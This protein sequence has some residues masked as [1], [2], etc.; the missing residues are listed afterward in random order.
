MSIR[1]SRFVGN[2]LA[3]QFDRDHI[4]ASNVKKAVMS[5][6]PTEEKLVAFYSRHQTA[7]LR[8]ACDAIQETPDTLSDERTMN[9]ADMWAKYFIVISSSVSLVLELLQK[10]DEIE[11]SKLQENYEQFL[12][13]NKLWKLVSC[14]DSGIRRTICELLIQCCYKQRH[15][16]SNNLEVLSKTFISKGLL[17][18]QQGSISKILDAL[19]ILTIEFPEIWEVHQRNRISR[20]G[21]TKHPLTELNSYILSG[22][23]LEPVE[24][25]KSLQ[26]LIKVLPLEKLPKK[27]E[28]FIEFLKNLQANFSGR[29]GMRANTKNAW[30][31]YMDITEFLISY[32]SDE[33]S[34]SDLLQKVIFPLFNKYFSNIL[35]WDQSE[36]NIGLIITSEVDFE[37]IFRAYKLCLQHNIKDN[38]FQNQWEMLG[39]RLISM[40]K[41]R[42]PEK[43]KN[44]QSLQSLV[45][46][47][48]KLWFILLAEVVKYLS[49]N[50]D[51]EIKQDPI[52]FKSI[53]IVEA[54]F[55]VLVS[56]DGKQYCAAEV[57]QDAIL[58]TPA[59]F[60]F[61][62]DRLKIV[63]DH[64]ITHLP[65]LLYSPSAALIIPIIFQ[66][67][68]LSILGENLE[69]I[70]L[71]I[72]DNFLSTYDSISIEVWAEI[73]I[74][75]ISHDEVSE[76]A[77]NHQN[78]QRF[79]VE[80]I[81]SFILQKH[82]NKRI[83]YAALEFNVLSQSS[84]LLLRDSLIKYL[85]GEYDFQRA[86][87]LLDLLNSKMHHLVDVDCNIHVV[88]LSRLL[89]I[90][91]SVLAEQKIDSEL[92]KKIQELKDAIMGNE[93]VQSMSNLVATILKEN[94]IGDHNL[95]QVHTPIITLD[96]TN[97]IRQCGMSY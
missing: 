85:N 47:L 51:L 52:V 53:E 89:A 3:G 70:W 57:L 76:I 56:R 8:Y 37:V 32:L 64:L 87:S 31:Y 25:W 75:L 10:L 5:L 2:W 28:E 6:L 63:R 73:A 66:Q 39:A 50:S 58:L 67:Q 49:N 24:F 96:V 72:I 55:E 91:E 69:S 20:K 77:Q 84:A 68:A 15:I 45:S 16:I 21:S 80:Q 94:G 38:A 43:T 88:L 48:S 79:L 42:L 29:V 44:F 61:S 11:R 23:R 17:T 83:F 60:T 41:I 65:K 7:T 78:L 30:D 81:D 9:K 97:K 90:E 40:L 34:L 19:R 74:T 14:E 12:S 92:V 59:L 4:V 62:P 46:R 18:P 35:D 54:A 26:H 13:N 33:D 1:V 71:G 27:S 86:L 95:S 82:S 93:Y 22:P 36:E